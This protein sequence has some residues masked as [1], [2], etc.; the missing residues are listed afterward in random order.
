MHTRGIQLRMLAATLAGVIIAAIPVT[1]TFAQV[2]NTNYNYNG[3]YGQNWHQNTYGYQGG[4]SQ[5]QQYVYWCMSQGGGYYSYMPCP[6]YQQPAPAHPQYQQPAPTYTHYQ[7]PV[8]PQPQ[9]YNYQYAYQYSPSYSYNSYTPQ[10]YYYSPYMNY[11]SYGYSY[12]S[13]EYSNEYNYETEWGSW[14]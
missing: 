5:P 8:Q 7:Q 6:A 9:Q 11:G 12:D 13:Y 10:Y 2:I 4:Y 3:S 14:D 1:I